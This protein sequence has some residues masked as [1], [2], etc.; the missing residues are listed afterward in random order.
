MADRYWVG[1]SGTWDGTTTTNWSATSG[2]AGGASAP[3]SA[4]NVFFNSASGATSYIVTSGAGAPAVCADMTMAGPAS[5]NVTWAGTSPC[6]IYGSMSLAATGVTVTLTGTLFFQSTTTGKTVT[7]N[8]VSLN[9][10]STTFN[11]VG[12]G[13]TL[14]SALTANTLTLVNGALSTGNYNVTLSNGFTSSYS[15]VRSLTLGSSTITTTGPTRWSITNSTNMT[16][17]AGTS[18]ITCTYF[19]VGYFTG[20]G[21]TYNNLLFTTSGAILDANNTFNNIT[22][23]NSSSGTRS[24]MVAG[25]QT[26]T[27]TLTL[28]GAAAN[29]RIVFCVG[30]LST[31]GR[32]TKAFISAAN[33]ALQNVDL[34]D[35]YAAGNGG[36]PW[37]GTNLG[38]GGGNVNVTFATPKTVYWNTP[39][40]G[41]WFSDTPNFATTSGGTKNINNTPL[42]QD[43]VI[44]DNT[45]ISSSSTISFWRNN[46]NSDNSGPAP[47]PNINV[48]ATNT[49]TL[50]LENQQFY[51]SSLVLQ[52]T[53]T[54]NLSFAGGQVLLGGPYTIT[55]NGAVTTG[56]GAISV[57]YATGTY[58]VPANFA[59][60]VQFQ[61]N[62]G[63]LD[64]DNQTLSCKSFSSSN[65]NQRK[66]LFR[67]GNITLTG[68]NVTIWDTTTTTNLTVTGTPVVNCTYSGSTGQR[69]IGTN[70]YSEAQA[71]SFNIKAGT[72]TVYFV[73]GYNAQIKNLD[74]TGF[75]GVWAYGNMF[76]Y[77]S[78]TLSSGITY[79]G[80]TTIYGLFFSSTSGTNTITS[81]GVTIIGP[82]TFNGVGGTWQLADNLSFETAQSM[83]LTA[84]TFDAVSSNVT[85][86]SFS[87]S[88]TGV[89]TIRFGSGTWTVAASGTSWNCTT[90]TNLTIVP[91]TATISMTSATAKTFAGGGKSYPKLN[92]GGAGDLTISGANTFADITAT[93]L[94]SGIFI[95]SSTTTTVSS[96]TGAGTV[97]NLL[98]F[99]S[100]GNPT[101]TLSKAS[102]VVTSGYLILRNTVATG[103][104]TWNA[105]AGS[106][107]AGTNTGWIFPPTTTLSLV[108]GTTWAVPNDWCE[109]GSSIIAFGA[110]AGGARAPSSS[111]SGPGGGGGAF[112]YV[113]EIGLTF[114]STVYINVGAAGAGGTSATP[115]GTAGGDTWLNKTVNSA[116]TLP[117]DGVLAKGGSAVAA[118]SSTGALGGAA[119]SGV[120]ALKKTGGKGGNTFSNAN[121]GAGG[122]GAA[123]T[124]V[125]DG[126]NGGTPPSTNV[127]TGGGGGGGVG[128]QGNVP[129]A[130][131]GGAGAPGGQSYA[132][133]AGGSGG[134]ASSGTGG[135]GT[136]GAG[137]GGGGGA[138]SLVPG[139]IGGAG[140]A[141]TEFSIT[142]GGTAGGGGG[143]G[144]AGGGEGTTSPGGAGGLYGG[145]GGGSSNGT[146]ISDGGAGAQGVIL[147]TYTPTNNVPVTG[148]SATADVGSITTTLGADINVVEDGSV[149]SV[150]TVTITG[151]AS[152]SVSGVSGTADVGSVTASIDASA[153]VTGLSATADVGTATTLVE[154]NIL[155]T[156]TSATGD[157]GNVSISGDG[158]VVL[159]SLLATMAL[160]NIVV[161]GTWDPVTPTTPSGAFAP[162]TNA[163][164]AGWISIAD[165]SPSWLPVNTTGVP[166]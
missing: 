59:I 34:C 105:G 162:I 159:T 30:P 84:G 93:S 70:T 165:P 102:G 47:Y 40:G 101:A 133:T 76:I 58:I 37:S 89:R 116:P 153:S 88:G 64:L 69:A 166:S 156:G 98:T 48:T 160:G 39:A 22:M 151:N 14:G 150:G 92:Q 66:I 85:V 33:L 100:A 157:V 126:F 9:S 90:G 73:N 140:G 136:N 27:G 19:D 36:R 65:S 107:N 80:A 2:G 72:D 118:A 144:G 60:S 43:T 137:G 104:A 81:N 25:N 56:S 16:L 38:D 6:T 148:N 62:F 7:T 123:A 95:P 131:S 31:Y 154:Q 164:S 141:G 138:A 15:N 35:I 24:L 106:I 21:L 124:L 45:G 1:G 46:S 44:I 10:L 78:L 158:S 152:V 28:T 12:G 94:P 74:F 113:S 128:G 129:A 41:V 130:T 54:L 63:T 96:F 97:G 135:A 4:D 121:Q 71:I 119:A 145:A 122:G 109:L 51:F 112:S 139:G 117:T 75:N 155:V 5:G 79:Q 99:S 68:N 3:T 42:P 147:V 91:G 20:G 111:T 49:V 161:S 53:V 13:W 114:G 163:P 50:T 86:G 108:S 134:S 18:T 125:I 8:G 17:N 67:N 29:Q 143:G 61:L 142:A 149:G 103:G 26:V 127:R 82:V 32:G 77:G 110:G 132:R 120:G 83:T 115:T 146:A 87:S 11:G 57:M 23:T 55:L 52:P